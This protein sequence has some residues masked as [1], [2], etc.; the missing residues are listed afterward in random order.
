MLGDT[1]CSQ[2]IPVSHSL[3]AANGIARL[4]PTPGARFAD[5]GADLSG[6]REGPRLQ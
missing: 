5:P 3:T 6:F 4:S 2:A 1:R